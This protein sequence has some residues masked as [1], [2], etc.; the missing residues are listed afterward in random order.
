MYALFVMARY[1]FT[2]LGPSLLDAFGWEKTDLSLLE[3]AM[4]FFY[5][6]AVLFNAAIVDRIGGRK[7]YLI[8][9]AGV[10]VANLVFGASFLMITSPPTIVGTEEAREVTVQAGFVYD[11]TAR[12]MAYILSAVWAFNAFFQSFGAMAILKI[13][14][15]WF[16]RKERGTF[17]AIFGVLIRTGMILAFSVVPLIVKYTSLS[18]GFWT[19]A[20]LIAVFAVLDYF[21]VRDT[22]EQAG[23]PAVVP[24]DHGVKEKPGLFELLLAAVPNR[25]VLPFTVASIMI[26]FVR[27]SVVDSWWPVYLKEV[28]EVSTASIIPLVMPWATTVLGIAGGFVLGPLSDKL[29]RRAPV[30]AT[31]FFGMIVGLALFYFVEPKSLNGWEA[32]ICIAFL[33]F[34]VNGV[35]GLIMGAAALDLGGKKGTASV[36]GVLDG[37]QYFVAAPFT[38]L[39]V[40]YIVSNPTYKIFG[41]SIPLGWETW[42][43][44]PIPFALVGLLV[45]IPVWNRKTDK[46]SAH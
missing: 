32:I 18:W 34:F 30:V 6:L 29:E 26:G 4:P 12:Q 23:H 41:Y 24:D 27:R 16:T 17:S 21:F 28:I 36:A 5:G 13:N 8:G 7:A 44:W 25:Y 42:K 2:A 45:M 37:A 22:P 14:A 40:G 11:L 35:H 38:G 39:L 1:N 20:G 19:P 33:S 10:I 43:L 15:Q 3:T 31:G 46:G 9:S